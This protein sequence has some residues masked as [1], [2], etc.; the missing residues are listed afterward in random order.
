MEGITRHI[1]SKYESAYL[2]LEKINNSSLLDELC[3]IKDNFILSTSHLFVIASKSETGKIKAYK[4]MIRIVMAE[5]FAG[6]IDKIMQIAEQFNKGRKNSGIQ[7]YI[8]MYPRD[9]YIYPSYS[10]IS[11]NEVCSNCTN[12]MSV[13]SRHSEL[14]C[15]ECGAIKELVGTVFEDFQ[16]Y[17]QEG[18]KAKSG[19]FNPNRHFQFWWS[20]IL[21]KEPEEELGDKTDNENLYGEKIL[22]EILKLIKRDNKILRLITVNEIRVILKELNRTDLNKNVPLI[23]KKLTGI[24]PPF[25]SNEVALKVENLFTKV[26]E[27][28][29][30][31]RKNGRVNRNYYPFYIFKII[32]QI[33]PD[34]HESKRILYYIYI[35]SE[36]TVKS[37]EVDWE[38]ICNLLPDEL[39]YITTDR[40]KI[41]KYSL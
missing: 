21:A 24:G 4:E 30:K 17:S 19:T 34:N 7:K 25:V 31:I 13:D 35:Q 27:V 41:S 20:R 26:I 29:E 10:L 32:E 39:I 23:M 16:F 9:E 37:N 2:F 12:K 6:E 36:E 22:K 33:L 3:L 11:D 38:E 40:Q 8:E 28:G 18:Q 14:Y 5:D 15:S 1:L